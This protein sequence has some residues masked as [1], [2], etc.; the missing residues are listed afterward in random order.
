[1]IR[2]PAKAPALAKADGQNTAET[3]HFGRPSR[4]KI[5][6]AICGI[7]LRD[8]IEFT[9][10][11]EKLSSN[12]WMLNIRVKIRCSYL[13]QTEKESSGISP[14]SSFSNKGRALPTQN[15]YAVSVTGLR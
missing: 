13:S 9:V 10:A 2:A 8:S 3:S 15:H 7:Q 5:S 1:M 4:R 12:V 6:H 11:S 14:P